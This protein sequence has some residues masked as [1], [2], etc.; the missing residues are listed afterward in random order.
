MRLFEAYGPEAWKVATLEHS[1]LDTRKDI[2]VWLI[3]F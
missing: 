3:R 1:T 2:E